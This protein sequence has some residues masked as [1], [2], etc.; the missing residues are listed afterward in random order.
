MP[1]LQPPSELGRQSGPRSGL[2]TG[3]AHGPGQPLSRAGPSRVLK[4][5]CVAC[6]GQWSLLSCARE[7]SIPSGA[8]N[9]VLP[10]L[11]PTDVP[12]GCQVS[13]M[14]CSAA[15]QGG[16]P[17]SSPLSRDFSSL[18]C[19]PTQN[20]SPVDRQGACMRA[21]AAGAG[22]RSE[23]RLPSALLLPS[24]CDRC[25]CC[26]LEQRL[27]SPSSTPSPKVLVQPAA[28]FVKFL[29]RI[30]ICTCTMPLI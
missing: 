23:P 19:A 26:L 20:P 2:C 30:N 22:A 25:P 11:P 3:K 6:L 5:L 13:G 12:R 15:S 7:V 24:D 10:L 17:P 28:H 4:P 29:C 1:G 16:A 14:Q 27:P 9:L 18:R 21:H 8:R